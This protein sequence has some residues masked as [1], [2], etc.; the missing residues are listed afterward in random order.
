M[1]SVNTYQCRAC[2]IFAG[3]AKVGTERLVHPVSVGLLQGQCRNQA[4]SLS[5][6]RSVNCAR[7]TM[8][9]G[10]RLIATKV[11]DPLWSI[12][13]ATTTERE[14]ERERGQHK[15]KREAKR[16]HMIVQTRPLSLSS[17][18]ASQCTR[19]FARAFQ[20][21]SPS[22]TLSCFGRSSRLFSSFFAASSSF[23]TVAAAQS[24]AYYKS[25]APARATT[26]Q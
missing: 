17:P 24:S 2:I 16:V 21:V 15:H 19:Y 7:T 3:L 6:S 13:G 22:L 8:R 11:R 9:C 25:T 14:R 18:S 26:W 4:L 20:R 23:A 10:N 5:F 1:S 12:G